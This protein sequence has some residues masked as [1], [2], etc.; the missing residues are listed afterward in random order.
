MRCQTWTEQNQVFTSYGRDV[1][2]MLVVLALTHTVLCQVCIQVR[3][4]FYFQ[5]QEVVSCIPPIP[6]LHAETHS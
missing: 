1:S 4:H 2:T 5:T 3:M 6:E